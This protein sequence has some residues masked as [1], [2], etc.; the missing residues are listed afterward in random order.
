MYVLA[1]TAPELSDTS[2]LQCLPPPGT[3]LLPPIV[4]FRLPT[5]RYHATFEPALAA[6][7]AKP[8]PHPPPTMDQRRQGRPEEELFFRP[9]A[10]APETPTVGPLRINKA[11]PPPRVPSASSGS[12]GGFSRPPPMP[13][14]PSPPTNPPTAPLPY[15]DDRAKDKAP[16]GRPVYTPL[17]A[18]ERASRNA[19]PPEHDERRR[20]SSTTQP[21]GGS[22]R[23]KFSADDPNRPTLSGYGH[24]PRAGEGREGAF[25]PSKLAERRGTVPKPLPDSQAQRRQRRRACSRSSLS[26]KARSQERCQT[27]IQTIINNTG[28]L[29]GAILFRREAPRRL[30][31]FQT[32]PVS[33]D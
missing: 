20:R 31:R 21:S 19:T 32:Q 28:H 5:P 8:Q 12:D 13:A 22:P 16:S 33:T 30:S 27:L 25:Q 4:I 29:P 7:I 15:P 18:Q 23:T 26:G 14:F 11:S 3:Q 6:K 17:S 10:E 1:T 9:A 24:A 2:S